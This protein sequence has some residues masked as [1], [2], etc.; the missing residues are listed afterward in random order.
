MITKQGFMGMDGFCWWLGVVENRDDPLK[1]GRVQARIFGWHTP[2]LK[3]IPTKDLPWA[4]PILP[5]NNADD[6]KTPKEGAYIFGFFL[7]GPSGQFPSYLGV[8]PGIPN[9]AAL[10]TDTPQSGFQD[11]RTPAQL[12]ASPTTPTSVT[13]PTDGSGASVT[14]QPA[15]RNPAV[16]G[17]PSVPPLAINDP[18]NPPAQIAQRLQDVVKDIAG[19]DNK[20]LATAIAGAAAGAQSALSGVTA[21][22]N[23]LV[24]NLSSLSSAL[25][26][27]IPSLSSGLQQAAGLASQLTGTT[28]TAPSAEVLQQAQSA[29]SKQL[30][31]AQAAATAAAAQAQASATEALSNLQSNAGTIANDISSNLSKLS[32]GSITTQFPVVLNSDSTPVI[33][34]NGLQVPLNQVSTM[35]ADLQSQLTALQSQLTS[36]LK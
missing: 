1:I 5:G 26:G 24:P 6:F 12:A 14:N 16:A 8:M 25:S 29:I 15:P 28:V 33:A 35:Q 9:A 3:L 18:A 4:H 13:A 32:S 19:P 23:S 20:N 11:I 21:N 2:D 10:Q 7:D 22:L 36:M 30:A 34:V 27:Q 17:Q 31:E